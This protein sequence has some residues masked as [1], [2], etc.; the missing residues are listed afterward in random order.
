[1]IWHVKVIRLPNFN[2]TVRHGQNKQIDNLTQCIPGKLERIVH[3]KLCMRKIQN[4]CTSNLD[5][6]LSSF[7]GSL[8]SRKRA[9]RNLSLKF[10]Q[11]YS[12]N[13]LKFPQ[14]LTI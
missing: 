14:I 11:R 13:E 3:C 1:M 10:K 7:P 2:E 12:F 6:L 5:I 8:Y 4:T 9:L